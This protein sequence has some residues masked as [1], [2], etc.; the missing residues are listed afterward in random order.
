MKAK[1]L[2]LS[3]TL[4]AVGLSLGIVIGRNK[5]AQ[6]S[7]LNQT[8][9]VQ[10]WQDFV[11]NEVLAQNKLSNDNRCQCGRARTREFSPSF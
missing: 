11:K 8:D 9:I 7:K 3:L 1:G 6:T 5:M 2:I 10:V 4:L